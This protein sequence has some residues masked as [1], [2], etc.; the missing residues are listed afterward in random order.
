MAVR[1]IVS[2]KNELIWEDIEKW[3][4]NLLVF[5][6]GSIIVAL[7]VLQQG[8]TF[9]EALFALYGSMVNAFIDLLRKFS[10]E[11]RYFDGQVTKVTDPI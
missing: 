5:S 6:S 7:V 10:G 8:G 9:Q 4:K 1:A 11:T 3:G 2:D